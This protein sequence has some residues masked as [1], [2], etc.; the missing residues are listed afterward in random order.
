[1]VQTVFQSLQQNHLN[2]NHPDDICHCSCC[3]LNIRNDGKSISEIEKY[4]QT[5]NSTSVLKFNTSVLVVQ[6]QLR[7][8]VGA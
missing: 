4:L 8:K 3:Q 6:R 1:M 5:N 7:Q 2:I